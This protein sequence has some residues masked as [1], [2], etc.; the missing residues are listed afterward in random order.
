MVEPFD[1][2]IEATAGIGVAPITGLVGGGI[3]GA[4]TGRALG[5]LAAQH[6]FVF[7]RS[8]RS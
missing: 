2:T 4:L 5:F 7:S 1:S 6:R 3:S 8:S